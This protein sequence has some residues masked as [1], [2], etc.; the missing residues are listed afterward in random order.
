MF[1]LAGVGVIYS[2]K[3]KRIVAVSFLHGCRK[4]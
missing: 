1:L 3:K 4:R 2:G